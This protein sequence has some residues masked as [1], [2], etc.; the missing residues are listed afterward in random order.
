MTNQSQ[1]QKPPLSQA[2]YG[3]PDLAGTKS[4]RHRSASAHEAEDFGRRESAETLKPVKEVSVN[5]Q[6]KSFRA[7]EAGLAG[8][9]DSDKFKLQEIEKAIDCLLSN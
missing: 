5:Q 3:N 1:F 8:I 2:N 4:A 9:N 6:A 7:K